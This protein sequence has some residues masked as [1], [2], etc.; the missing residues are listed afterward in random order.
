MPHRFGRPTVKQLVLYTLLIVAALA[1][2]VLYLLGEN[3]VFEGP[4]KPEGTYEVVDEV[5]LPMYNVK[6]LSPAASTDEDTYYIAPLIYDGLFR[7]DETMTPEKNLAKDYRYDPST[8]SIT[9]DLI[10]TIW[11]DG[12]PLTGA[13]VAFTIEVYK[14]AGASCNYKDLIDNIGYVESGERSVTI[15]FNEDRDMGPDLLTF[16]ILPSHRYDYVGAALAAAEDFVPVGTGAYKV[17]SYDPAGRLVLEPNEHYHGEVPSNTLIFDTQARKGDSYQLLQ[18]GGVSLMVSRD[19][20]R[21]T[22]ITKKDVEIVD[23]PANVVEFVGFNCK[24]S[25]FR[26][27]AVR[28]AVCYAID[29]QTIIEREYF[30]SGMLNDGLFFPGY[31]GVDSGKETYPYDRRKAEEMLEKAGYTQTD[32]SGNITDTAGT[33]LSVT[34]LVN[35][36]S[37]ERS[38]AA[39]IVAES[40]KDLGAVVTVTELE[41]ED[42]YG[43]LAAGEFDLYFGTYT[44]DTR[45]DMRDLFGYE[46]TNYAGYDSDELVALLDDLR[47]GET[48]EEMRETFIKAR[49]KTIEDVPYYCIA[50]R[51][52]GAITTST[53]QGD[54]HAVFCD[55][56]RGCGAWQSRYLVPASEESDEEE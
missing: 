11:Q 19:A 21:A 27:K 47:S 9:V 22:Y 23:F 25:T 26:K 15:F 6:T 10:D 37:T 12:R 28:Q 49:D 55:Y 40:L 48:V 5:T 36:D 1:V 45:M 7:L 24:G 31:L 42:Y 39:Q 33:P 51:T 50:Y 46:K 38:G 32:D 30:G 29:S 17:K 16:P 44:F 2:V 34:I 3:E 13:D 4:E 35:A 41:G 43:A 14:A 18:A 56:Y 20:D 52:Y 53:F 8:S 54:I